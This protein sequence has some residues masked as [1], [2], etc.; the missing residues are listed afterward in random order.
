[1]NRLL[2]PFQSTAANYTLYG[3]LFGLGFPIIAFF[4]LDQPKLLFIMICSAPVFL[5]LFAWLAGKKHDDIED[6]VEMRTK[7]LQV[8]KDFA[9]EGIRAKARFL[10]TMSHEIRTPMN[11]VL[12]C[13]NLMLD[14]A[15]NAENIRL[16]KTVQNSGE[17]LLTLIN[18]I[19]DFSK[20]ES[21]KLA[22]ELEP[23]PL[24]E[25]VEETIDLMNSGSS[26][27]GCLL[28]CNLSPDVPAW[29]RGDVTRLRQV[30]TNLVSNAIKFTKDT[31]K[32][33][34][35]ATRDEDG[36]HHVQVSVVDNGVGIPEESKRKLFQDFSQVDA[37]T[38]RKYGGT[39]LG[40]AICKGIIQAMGGKIW[41]ESEE[42]KG[43]TF[44][45]SVP[46]EE[47]SPGVSRKRSPLAQVNESMAKTHPLRLLMAEDNSVNQMAGRKLLSKLGYRVDIVGNGLEALSAVQRQSYDLIF[48]DQHMPEMDGVEATI[49]IRQLELR[50][51]KI[52]AL[53]ASAF[54]EDKERCLNAGMDGFLTKPVNIHDLVTALNECEPNIKVDKDHAPTLQLDKQFILEQVAGEEE[55]LSEI[56]Q[57]CLNCIPQYMQAIEAA[58]NCSDADALM[59]SAHALKGTV[60]NFHIESVVDAAK[61]LENL[62]RSNELDDALSK[63]TTL[64]SQV[65]QLI[66]EIEKLI[67]QPAA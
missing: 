52:F 55:I 57:E 36:R 12:S 2:Q 44:S 58:I 7:E 37:S 18:D 39:G 33:E 67:T 62:G 14:T 48:M 19:L 65:D 34:V 47:T 60:A 63:L 42:G 22:L 20:I 46:L 3:S 41:V 6:V 26:E 8:A 32:V 38:T 49:K 27:R 13:T 51:P 66:P 10:A 4:I 17:T 24:R 23:F 21:G 15:E 43:S 56:A 16:L 53:T 54:K 25:C 64:Q 50:Q 35:T 61:T 1:M 59:K 45:F 28:S 11:A 30:V 31:V 9:E 5:G 29:V 40:L